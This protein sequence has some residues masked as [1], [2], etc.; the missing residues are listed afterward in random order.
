MFAH[1]KLHENKIKI[2]KIIYREFLSKPVISD[3][4][5]HT[6][7]G[8]S[9]QKHLCTRGLTQQHFKKYIF[10][11]GFFVFQWTCYLRFEAHQKFMA[12]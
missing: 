8:T 7:V 9:M 2:H 11:L 12:I 6:S 5:D 10:V 3:L 4:S 1:H